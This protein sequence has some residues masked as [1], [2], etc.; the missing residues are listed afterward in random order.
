MKCI[1]DFSLQKLKSVDFSKTSTFSHL[2]QY[3]IFKTSIT[4]WTT[5]QIDLTNLTLK[6]T[7]TENDF[8]IRL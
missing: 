2:F 8:T 4:F 1:A 6:Q 3:K 5:F 7:I